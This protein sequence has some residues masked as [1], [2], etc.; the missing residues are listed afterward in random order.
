MPA[1]DLDETSA[2]STDRDDGDDRRVAL[3][4]V[5]E[6]AA[7]LLPSQGPITVFVH[8]NT[9]HAFEHLDFDAGVQ[10]GGR[11][12]GCHAYLPEERY[13]EKLRRG[14]IRVEDLEAVLQED[15]GDEA[16]RLV[17]IFCTRYALRLSM[18]QFSLHTGS[19]HELRWVVAE[20]DALRR[21]RREVTTN[22]RAEML[23]D[24]RK[25]VLER[26]TNQ[27]GIRDRVDEV[28]EQFDAATPQTWSDQTW[29]AFVLNYLWRACC[30]GVRKAI[31]ANDGQPAGDESFV[32][33]RDLLVEAGGE[34]ADLLVHETLIR[35]CS[36]FLD[37]GF[38]D[39]NLPNREKGLFGAFLRQHAVGIMAPTR[40]FRKLSREC[41]R[42]LNDKTGPL[43]SIDES[44]TLLGVSEPE[45]EEFITQSMLALRGWAGMVWQ[46]ES[47]AE[48][49]PHPAPSDKNAG[50]CLR[51]V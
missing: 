5:I 41:R 26:G 17:S 46:M 12:F 22:V 37:Q 49:A 44:L 11:L 21:F 15:L 27:I 25:A 1:L 14:R 24:T 31:G 33:H 3:R 9:L 45:Q 32:R 51:H 19:T 35:F 48:W 39:W 28:L 34:D 4:H 13:R 29:E 7:H 30:D 23:S 10:A 42:L 6:H 36:A 18:L 2:K 43:E 8:H 20:T 40:W 47:N 50:T 38:A 16:D